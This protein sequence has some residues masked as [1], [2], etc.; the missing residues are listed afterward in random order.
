MI[1]G[2]YTSR[3]VLSVLGVDDYGIYIFVGGVVAL[4]QVVSSTFVASTQRSISFE[5]GKNNT[6]R[7]QQVFT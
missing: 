1:V 5:L 2:I 6:V 3:V 4:F 7:A